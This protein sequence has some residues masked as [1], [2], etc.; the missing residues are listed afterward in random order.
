M[1]GAC[2]TEGAMGVETVAEEKD[3]TEAAPGVDE[4]PIPGKKYLGVLFVFRT[5]Y[6]SM[7]T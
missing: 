3:A 2:K 5:A 1:E 7:N 6:G 4:L